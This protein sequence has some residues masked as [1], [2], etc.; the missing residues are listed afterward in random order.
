MCKNMGKVVSSYHSPHD[1]QWSTLTDVL[2]LMPCALAKWSSQK[3]VWSWASLLQIRSCSNHL[4]RL[5][6][7]CSERPPSQMRWLCTC[8]WYDFHSVFEAKLPFHKQRIGLKASSALSMACFFT[9]FAMHSWMCLP[10]PLGIFESLKN[11]IDGDD[12]MGVW[13]H[14]CIPCHTRHLS[15]ASM[16][17]RMESVVVS[18]KRPVEK[19]FL[20][21]SSIVSQRGKG[22][23]TCRS[24]GLFSLPCVMV[25]LRCGTT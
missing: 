21:N 17:P 6:S 16:Y 11:K 3:D 4:Q 18:N 22:L 10:I 12:R 15:R 20:I 13:S 5:M 7:P 14:M 24:P 8:F 25:G 19:K 2:V 1:A 9:V 23:E